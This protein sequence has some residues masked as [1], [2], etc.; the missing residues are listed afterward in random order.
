MATQSELGATRVLHIQALHDRATTHGEILPTPGRFGRKQ[1]DYRSFL[2]IPHVGRGPDLGPPPHS[3]QPAA[4][5]ALQSAVWCLDWPSCLMAGLQ[6]NAELLLILEVSMEVWN[7]L[8]LSR[9]RFLQY[10]L[11]ASCHRLR[12]LA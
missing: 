4:V 11:V 10:L 2:S 12:G 1:S 3:A 8:F 6:R 7:A 5:L 9:N